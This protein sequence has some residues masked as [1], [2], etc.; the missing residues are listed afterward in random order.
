MLIS[1]LLEGGDEKV[2]RQERETAAQPTP[3]APRFLAAISHRFSINS[4]DSDEG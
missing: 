3:L 4:M 1:L 2:T